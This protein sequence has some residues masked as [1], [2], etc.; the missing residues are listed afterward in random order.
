MG[1]YNQRMVAPK[2]SSRGSRKSFSVCAL[3]FI[4]LLYQLPLPLCHLP[5]N[6]KIIVITLILL[7]N[8]IEMK[9]CCRRRGIRRNPDIEVNILIPKH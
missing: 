8:K 2:I 7:L 4:E 5:E 6:R 1:C 3:L 9:I